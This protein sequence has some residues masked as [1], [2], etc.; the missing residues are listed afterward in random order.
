MKANKVALIAQAIGMYVMHIP[1]YIFFI[2]E[3][4]PGL[5]EGIVTALVKA[6]VILMSIGF[7]I[8]VVNAV[9]SV[10]SIFKGGIDPSKTVMK[11]K[12][13]LIPWYALNF[14]MC[15]IIVLL[16]FNPFTLLGVPVVVALILAG[17][18][19]CML[20]TSLPDV[21]YY[22]RKVFVEK[23]EAISKP[24]VITVILLFIFCLDVFA[25]VSFYRQ[26]KKAELPPIEE[27]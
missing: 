12:L 25:G 3:F 15:F 26:N 24:R 6:A 18:Y 13:A 10:I 7:A 16:L 23:T 17:T 4:F 14:A 22:L 11:V 9:L 2:V 8:C 5:H 1:L 20:T 19:F 21:A 27:N